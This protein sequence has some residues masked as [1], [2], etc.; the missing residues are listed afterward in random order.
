MTT[1]QQQRYEFEAFVRETLGG[2]RAEMR[3]V[4]EASAVSTRAIAEHDRR[5]I[6]NE[7]E[8]RTLHA[9]MQRI[10]E[11]LDQLQVEVAE[12]KAQRAGMLLS[13]RVLGAVFTVLGAVIHWAFSI[14]QSGGK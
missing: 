13:V 6:G 2:L 14:W 9:D 1:E 4:L 12:L 3:Q 8:W 5:L 10:R 7:G 11:Q